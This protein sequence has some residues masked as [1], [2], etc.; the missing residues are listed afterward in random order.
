MRL[1]PLNEFVRDAQ[2]Q[3]LA[4]CAEA[5]QQSLRWLVPAL[6]DRD[7]AAEVVAAGGEILPQGFETVLLPPVDPPG[8][9]LQ[10]VLQNLLGA[11]CDSRLELQ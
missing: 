10:L 6:G 4:F 11:M 1:V 9:A 2:Q 5:R 7:L 3:Q 8:Q